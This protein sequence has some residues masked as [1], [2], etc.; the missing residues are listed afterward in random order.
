ML[1]G[2]GGQRLRVSKAA[3]GAMI[4]F[5][6]A[7]TV[8]SVVVFWG[9]RGS[10]DAQEPLVVPLAIFWTVVVVTLIWM[11]DGFVGTARRDAGRLRHDLAGQAVSTTSGWGGSSS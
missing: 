9:G 7:G 6:R 8:V 10:A 2:G 4:L 3:K 5:A 11:L 1:R